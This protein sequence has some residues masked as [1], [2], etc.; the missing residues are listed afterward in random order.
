MQSVMG[1]LNQVKAILI[2]IPCIQQGL[3]FLPGF[4]LSMEYV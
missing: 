3:H 2:A 4:R 1:A